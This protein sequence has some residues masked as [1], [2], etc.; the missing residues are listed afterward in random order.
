MLECGATASVPKGHD[1]LLAT[2]D[3]A[4]V[5][6]EPTNPER[7][8]T[9]LSVANHSLHENASPIL[10]LEPGGR[11][12]TSHC[13]F[14]AVSP[15]AVRISGMAW[16]PRLSSVKLEGVELVGYRAI[17]IGGTRDPLLIRQFDDFIGRVRAAVEDKA[18]AFGVTPEQYRLVLRIYGRDGVM[19]PTEPVRATKAHELGILVEVIADTQ[20]IANAVLAVARVSLLHTDFPGRLCREGNMAF[21]FSPSDAEI[22]PHYRFSIFHELALADPLAPFTIEYEDL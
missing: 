6:V 8:C 1:C 4:G 9:P 22:A 12:D 20:E 16:Q 10:H 13:N 17:T 14:E 19:G 15:R 7:R 2:V 21:P 5:E 18:A 3:D 11:L